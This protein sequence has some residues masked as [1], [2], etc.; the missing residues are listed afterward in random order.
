MTGAISA[1]SVAGATAAAAGAGTA[2]IAGAALAANAG[3]IALAGTAAS[4]VGSIAQGQAAAQAAAYNAQ[5]QANNAKIATENASLA[6][7]EGSANVEAKSLQTRAKV[8]A[9]EANQAA[10]GIDIGSGSAT[11]VRQ[12]ATQVGALEAL[13]IRANATRQAYGYQTQAASDL[14]QSELDKKESSYDKSAGY[15]KAGATLLSS[16]GNAWGKYSNSNDFT[17]GYTSDNS[18]SER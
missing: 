4:A 10:A 14:A 7:A 15:L 9:I 5:I 12:S 11:D 2:G 8:G 1:V 13:N 18:L 16:A 17:G 3:A 6:G